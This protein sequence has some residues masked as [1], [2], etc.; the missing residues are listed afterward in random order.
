[1]NYPDL[2]LSITPT[3]KRAILLLRSTN[4]L[5]AYAQEEHI[6]ISQEQAQRLILKI[7]QYKKELTDDD[8]S[9]LADIPSIKSETPCR[10]CGSKTTELAVDNYCMYIQ[11]ASC[12]CNIIEI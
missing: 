10:Y 7:K 11:C 5:M 1:M 12:K 3:Q 8:K 4:D 2:L 9:A 6:D